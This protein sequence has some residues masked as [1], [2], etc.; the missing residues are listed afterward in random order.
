MGPLMIGG[1][2]V[3]STFLRDDPEI[4]VVTGFSDNDSEGVRVAEESRVDFLE[5]V[6]EVEQESVGVV[7]GFG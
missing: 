1:G 7:Y 4:V 3:L 6:V 5:T 2:W